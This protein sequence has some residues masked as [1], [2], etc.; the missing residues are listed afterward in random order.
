MTD[1]RK[2]K[3]GREALVNAALELAERE[4]WENVRLHAIAAECGCGLDAL[5]REFGDKD[6]IIDAWLDRADAAVLALHDNGGLRGLSVRERLFHL[7]M[8][9]LDTLAPHRRVT[10]EMITHKL[11]PGHV[12]V[13]FPALL[14]ISR[15]VQWIREAAHLDAPLPR[16]ALEET[17]LTALF[18]R[19]FGGWLGDD[20]S[21]QARTRDRLD[22]RL[23]WL[24]SAAGAVPGGRF[25]GDD[26]ERQPDAGE[27]A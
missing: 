9:W 3:P 21:A 12:H 22:R 5:G 16:R 10:R 26:A 2:R 24:E 8:V 27:A 13:Q 11:E 15:T 17:A 23:A 14:R 25:S 6:E 1:R 7:F 18:V 20:S 19:T 4:G